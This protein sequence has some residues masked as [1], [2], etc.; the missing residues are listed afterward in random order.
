MSVD[1]RS[2]VDGAREVSRVF[3]EHGGRGCVGVEGEVF[4]EGCEVES[5]VEEFEK[6]YAEGWTRNGRR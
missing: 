4:F 2:R 6:A 5:A 1:G 3:V